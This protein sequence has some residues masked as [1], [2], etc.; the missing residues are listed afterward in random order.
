MNLKPP[1][2][3]DNVAA[4]NKSANQILP[5]HKPENA[6]PV[7]KEADMQ[8]NPPGDAAGKAKTNI[9]LNKPID[10][11]ND[12]LNPDAPAKD[13]SE[14]KPQLQVLPPLKDKMAPAK[15]ENGE[16]E[17]KSSKDELPNA[18]AAPPANEDNVKGEENGQRQAPPPGGQGEGQP[19]LAEGQGQVKAAEGA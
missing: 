13:N 11:Q 4:F 9:P 15:D 8:M 18:R 17:G 7:D 1:Q 2:V 6:H 5:P 12:A 10:V 14:E 3:N 19:P 16:A